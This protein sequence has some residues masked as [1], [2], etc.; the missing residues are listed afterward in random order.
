MA[1]PQ[2]KSPANILQE[3]SYFS[4]AYGGS[5]SSS[6]RVQTDKC[7][8]YASFEAQLSAVRTSTF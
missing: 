6:I 5:F 4:G 7:L 1:N 2:N 8:N 3:L